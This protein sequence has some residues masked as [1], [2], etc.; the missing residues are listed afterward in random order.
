MSYAW[1]TANRRLGLFGLAF[2]GA[3]LTLAGAA[4]AA[5]IYGDDYRYGPPRAH[6]DPPLAPRGPVYAR[7]PY[8][9]PLIERRVEV[10]EPACRVVHRRR[11]DPYGREVIHRLRVCDEDVVRRGYERPPYWASRSPR[12]GDE[13]W[14]YAP[15]PPRAV[16]PDYDD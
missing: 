15:R 3:F 13:N 14:G 11:I 2:A 7:P 1:R 16:G 12:Y 8:A 10:D 4:H 6:Y 5:D 9:P